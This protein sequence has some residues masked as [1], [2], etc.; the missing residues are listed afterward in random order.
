MCVEAAQYVDVSLG[1]DTEAVVTLVQSTV[2]TWPPWKIQQLLVFIHKHRHES[3][4]LT[5]SAFLPLHRFLCVRKLFFNGLLA[6]TDRRA[7]F[8][9]GVVGCKHVFGHNET[10]FCCFVIFQGSVA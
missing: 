9:A 5:F 8:P 7:S 10:S 6:R 2:R 3:F 1:T 4:L